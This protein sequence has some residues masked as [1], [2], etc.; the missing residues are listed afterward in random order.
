MAPDHPHA[1]SGKW[2]RPVEPG[3]HLSQFIERTGLVEGPA[4]LGTGREALQ[5]PAGVLP[6]ILDASLRTELLVLLLS[7]RGIFRGALLAL[8]WRHNDGAA[9]TPW[10]RLTRLT[11]CHILVIIFVFG[12]HLR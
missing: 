4:H 12:A 8:F 9:L 6:E 3:D 7:Q 11:R 2:N 5:V 10:R 1:A